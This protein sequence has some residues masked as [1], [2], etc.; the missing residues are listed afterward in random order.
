M[1]QAGPAKDELQRERCSACYGAL[2]RLAYA[3]R[4]R[5]VRRGFMSLVSFVYLT[6]LSIDN[7]LQPSDYQ[8]ECRNESRIYQ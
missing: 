3:H 1:V 2:M 7:A 4:T 8:C 6:V 5:T